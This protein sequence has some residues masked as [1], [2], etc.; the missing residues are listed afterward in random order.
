MAKYL[1]T[2][3]SHFTPFTY[4]EMVKPLQEMTAAHNAAQ[5]K[6]DTLNLE[7]EALRNYI[8]DDE[9]DSEV[10]RRYDDY[11]AKL[12]KFQANLMENGIGANTMS[13]LSAA[14]A[15]YAS[16]ITRIANAIKS[17]QERSNAYWEAKHKNP[18]LILGEDPG[19]AG[20]NAYFNDDKYGQDFYSYSGNA[21]TTE[22]GAD[23]K[24]R[25]KELFKDAKYEINNDVPGY[26]KKTVREGAT[27]DEVSHAIN[28][29]D[30]ILF[31]DIDKS[32]AIEKLTEPERVLTEV[33]V[34]HMEKTGAKGKV[35]PDEY[36]RAFDYA[37]AGLSHAIGGTT[38]TDLQDREFVAKK[39]GDGSSYTSGYPSFISRDIRHRTSPVFTD[40]NNDIDKKNKVYKTSPSGIMINRSDGTAFKSGDP[41][42]TANE[43]FNNPN[44]PA[45]QLRIYMRKFY[46]GLDIALPN[47]IEQTGRIFKNGE[48]I[49]IITKKDG[50]GV[51]IVGNKDG[52][53]F[54]LENETRDFNIQRNKYNAYV[55]KVREKNSGVDL[56]S[57]MITPAEMYEMY[58]KAGIDTRV[59]PSDF[60]YAL[61]AKEGVW[62]YTNS[63]LV[64]PEKSFDPSREVFESRIISG[65]SGDKGERFKAYVVTDGVLSDDGVGDSTKIF[66]TN[67]EGKIIDGSL[68]TVEFDP[69]EIAKSAIGV[70]I[71]KNRPMYFFTTNNEP[72]KTWAADITTLGD[73]FNVRFNN[74]NAPTVMYQALLPIIKPDDALLMSNESAMNWADLIFKTLNVD[75]DKP[76]VTPTVVENGVRRPA[77]PAEI[78]RD[79][80]LQEQLYNAARDW[81]DRLFYVD[82]YEINNEQEK[83][84]SLTTNKSTDAN[85]QAILEQ[86][87]G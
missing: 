2:S 1:V 38:V 33:L 51:K 8:S 7:T 72:G 75:P 28:A 47:D 46:N 20:L 80:R 59:D 65:I 49:T 76:V 53:E 62:D 71:G 74:A 43:L 85:L 14:R 60:Y 3:D 63:V 81:L 44:N 39:G 82:R 87:Y 66:P 19:L 6:Y 26:Y 70:S 25:I 24:T 78:V 77:L 17:R 22:V 31:D 73:E 56:D 32:V 5:E 4:D 57:M 12:G 64:N 23:A 67:K 55:S 61:T 58:K 36:K 86:L 10:K 37:S 11:M 18:D 29:A 69:I 48:E 50:D 79:K 52:K 68:R 83:H 35:S 16:D 42:F 13:E 21:L 27:S 45:G 15:A 34:S 41:F 84:K 54:V 30:K 9:K 40:I